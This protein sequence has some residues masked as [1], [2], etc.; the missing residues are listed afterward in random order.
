MG[1][2]GLLGGRDS[3]FRHATYPMFYFLPLAPDKLGQPG[4]RWEGLRFMLDISRTPVKLPGPGKKWVWGRKG[5]IMIIVVTTGV[6][7]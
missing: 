1:K 7:I 3:S 2:A 5:D 4:R 6:L